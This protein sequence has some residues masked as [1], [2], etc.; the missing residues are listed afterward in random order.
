MLPL[1]NHITAKLILPRT[2]SLLVSDL[3]AHRRTKLS[4]LEAHGMHANLCINIGICCMYIIHILGLRWVGLEIIWKTI[5][6]TINCVAIEFFFGEEA[7]SSSG[8]QTRL[9]RNRNKR[10][11]NLILISAVRLC[12]VSAKTKEGTRL[13][14]GFLSDCSEN[15]KKLIT[16]PKKV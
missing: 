4:A 8:L 11:L 1:V 3:L 16:Y 9:I 12:S 10:I 5:Q 2:L 13:L 6:L 7:M 14:V 15:H